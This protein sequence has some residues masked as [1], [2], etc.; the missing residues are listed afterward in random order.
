MRP[1]KIDETAE[2][3]ISWSDNERP[4][5][6]AIGDSFDGAQQLGPKIRVRRCRS[7]ELARRSQLHPFD[8]QCL[9]FLGY[10]FCSARKNDRAQQ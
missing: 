6:I 9:L 8:H 4:E 7:D 10:A 5:E 2:G 3:V 1:T